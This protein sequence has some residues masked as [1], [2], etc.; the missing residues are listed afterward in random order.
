MGYHKKMFFSKKCVP[1]N[2]FMPLLSRI[3]PEYLSQIHSFIQSSLNWN[4]AQV[5]G[6]VLASHEFMSEK[7]V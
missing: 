5:Q 3:G 7:L 4:F 2:V 6:L 1:E